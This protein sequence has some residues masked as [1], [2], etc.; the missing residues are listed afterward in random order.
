MK[1]KGS[2]VL[3]ADI[4]GTNA[5]LAIVRPRKAGAEILFQ[6][7]EE[8]SATTDFVSVVNGF[9]ELAKDE[10]YEPK[11]GCFAVAGPVEVMIDRRRVKMTNVSV[12]VDSHEIEEKTSLSHVEVMN[13]F[14]AVSYGILELKESDCLTLNGGKSLA[15]ATRA[16]VGAGTGLGKSILCFNDAV[17]D[18]LPVPSEGGHA[19]LPLLAQEELDLAEFIRKERKLRHAITYED[20]LSGRGLEIL[21]QY[22]SATRFPDVQ[23]GL[24]AE[25]ISDSL[26]D[27]PCSGNAFGWFVRFY[28][29]CARNFV[30]DT[31][32][33]GG[34]YIAGGIAAKNSASFSGFM[35]EFVKN[36]EYGDLLESVPV[37]L[38][39]NYDVSLL[40]AGR[41]LA[42]IGTSRGVS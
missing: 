40:G 30:L 14:E 31:L 35:G 37:R 9:L 22:L 16:V 41:A 17:G 18:Y 6:R 36:D 39:T 28:A 25:A 13:D 12:I 5:N 11:S 4:G 20:V 7:N 27:N 32:A 34:L 21:Y 1:K 23:R 15:R 38:I 26:S 8:T 3:A 42:G 33:R 19:D 24:S 2:I 10:G 29:R